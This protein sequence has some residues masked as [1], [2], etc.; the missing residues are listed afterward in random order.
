MDT[1]YINAAYILSYVDKNKT[2]VI[3]SPSAII[4]KNEKLYI[5]E[6]EKTLIPENIVSADEKIIKELKETE[7]HI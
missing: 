5:N 2:F 6:F 4:N 3:N 1:D 7:P